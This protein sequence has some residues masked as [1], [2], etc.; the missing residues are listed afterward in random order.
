MISK[1]NKWI[2]PE[3]MLPEENQRVLVTYR[4]KDDTFIEIMTA[5]FLGSRYGWCP[6]GSEHMCQGGC[7]FESVVAWMP[8]PEPYREA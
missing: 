8:L 6:D 4:H 2:K 7:S 5:T 1:M 3:N